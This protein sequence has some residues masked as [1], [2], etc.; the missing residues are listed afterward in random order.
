MTSRRLLLIAGGILA[1]DQ[2]TKAWVLAHAEWAAA[3]LVIV[4]GI[5]EL[6]SWKNPGALFSLFADAQGILPRILLTL[7]P[8]CA[9]ALLVLL[10][11]RN[12]GDGPLARLGYALVLGGAT[13]NL[14]DRIFRGGGVIDFLHFG[15]AHDPF[16]GW[17]DGVFGTH[18]WP[19]FNVADSAICVGAAAIAADL[20]RA[21]RGAREAHASDP[22]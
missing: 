20:L 14:A 3:P 8:T 11:L 16:R 4:P 1:A 7:L 15:I 12:D 13:G 6:V 10:I 21:R 22:L 9:I 18:W 2:I 5:F 19:A 17:L